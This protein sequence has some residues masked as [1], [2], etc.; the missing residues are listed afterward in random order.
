MP[1]HLN[2]L[3]HGGEEETWGKGWDEG[4]TLLFKA[5]FFEVGS[6]SGFDFLLLL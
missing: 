1:P 3:P 2:P 4:R 6:W 5:P